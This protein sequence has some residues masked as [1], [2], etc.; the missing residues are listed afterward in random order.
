MSL[1]P[2]C[3][4]CDR[5]KLLYAKTNLTICPY[6]DPRCERCNHPKKVHTNIG[7]NTCQ[8]CKT[9]SMVWKWNTEKWYLK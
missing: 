3:E 1:E 2:R 5:P 6:C 8:L 4:N 9:C 7:N